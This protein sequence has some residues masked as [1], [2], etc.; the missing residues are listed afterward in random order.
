MPM[1]VNGDL[2]ETDALAAQYCYAHY[3]PEHFGI[4]NFPREC[5][6]ICLKFTEGRNQQHALDMGCAV[7]R[8]SFE[9]ARGFDRVTALDYSARFI[10]MAT[11]MQQGKELC[12]RVTEEGETT[13]GHRASLE[14][15]GL[16]GVR[17]KVAFARADACDLPPRYSGYDLVLAAN[18]IDRLRFPRRFLEAMGQRI[19]P[20]GLLVITSPYT[21]LE[22][23]TPREEWLGGY[24]KE[25]QDVAALDGLAAA[26][27]QRFRMLCP[28]CDIPFVI[29]ETRRKFQHTIAEM[30]VWERTGP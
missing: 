18:L 10:D 27:A 14:E 12:Y 4:P 30:T 22:E 11:R 20:G 26:L 7:G 1:P 2:Y 5:A 29:R 24:R 3:G 25:G 28:P 19:N 9:L 8:S 17:D 13:T 23:F 16:E 6:R 15:L 21:W